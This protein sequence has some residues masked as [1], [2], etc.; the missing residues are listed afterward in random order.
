MQTIKYS[1]YKL[2]AGVII[3]IV[4]IPFGL[5][6]L[7]ADRTKLQFAGVVLLIIGPLISLAASLKLLGKGVAIH[8][9]SEY[10][11]IEGMWRKRKARW[12]EIES[13]GLYNQKL[14]IV[15][16]GSP[17]S[18]AYIYAD[19]GKGLFGRD[20]ISVSPQFLSISVKEMRH[21]ATEISLLHSLVTKT[22]IIPKANSINT[23]N[24][25]PEKPIAFKNRSTSNDLMGGKSADLS[26]A[27]RNTMGF[28][29]KGL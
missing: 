19:F 15:S 21:I 17:K 7:D 20:R 16:I 22:N 14:P 24:L 10:L 11:Y 29:K 27:N 2:L 28:G 26:G 6:L 25:N 12:S 9:D 4:I 5:E 8:Y 1:T 3:G 23:A 18:Y 13:A